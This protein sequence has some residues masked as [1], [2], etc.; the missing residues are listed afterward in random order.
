MKTYSIINKTIKF[1]YKLNRERCER[2][3]KVYIT[4][5][6]QVFPFFLAADTLAKVTIGFNLPLFS[7]ISNLNLKIIAFCEKD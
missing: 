6:R 5:S 1:Q 7:L 4:I 3:M 2:K